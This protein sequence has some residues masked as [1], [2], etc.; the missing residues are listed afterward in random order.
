MYTTNLRRQVHYFNLLHE[1]ALTHVT[2]KVLFTGDFPYFVHYIEKSWKGLW[3][4][5]V[6]FYQLFGFPKAD[7]GPLMRR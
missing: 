7:F 6:F 4:L 1:V 3:N 5:K 2:S